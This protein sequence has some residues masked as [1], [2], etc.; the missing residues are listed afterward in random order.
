MLI[1]R[2]SKV[3]LSIYIESSILRVVCYPLIYQD[4][5]W[6]HTLD[7]DMR[8][9]QKNFV[10]IGETIKEKLNNL[11]MNRVDNAF[12]AFPMWLDENWNKFISYSNF[13]LKIFLKKFLSQT[14]PYLND[15][16]GYGPYGNFTKFNVVVVDSTNVN[17][18]SP[19][20]FYY[21]KSQKRSVVVGQDLAQI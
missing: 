2:W 17:D 18:R 20:L 1:D 11:E 14:F 19:D 5:D 6:K 16:F 21:S 8:V 3:I 7:K 9:Q 10:E 4:N 12:R 13:F 15:N